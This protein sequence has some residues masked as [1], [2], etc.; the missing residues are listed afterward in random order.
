MPEGA[1]TVRQLG[2]RTGGP[3][4][5]IIETLSTSTPISGPSAAVAHRQAR[6]PVGVTATLARGRAERD[7]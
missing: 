1:T 3:Y 5:M 2:S 7:S 6:R 4:V